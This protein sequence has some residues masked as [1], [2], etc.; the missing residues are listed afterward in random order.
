MK[1]FIF[2]IIALFISIS[3]FAQ[4]GS[5]K[6]KELKIPFISERVNL[7]SEEAE[8]FWPIYNAYD[9]ATSKIKHEEIRGIHREIKKNSTTLDDQKSKELLDRLN[10]AENIL[11]DEDVKLINKLSKIISPKK[12]LL[13]KIAEEDFKKR[14]FDRYIKKK[15]DSK[16]NKE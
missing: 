12:I 8:K 16:K 10:K 3:A 11:H 9:D 14:L 2:A 6:F 5:K 13:L 1:N 7:S 15:C 4:P